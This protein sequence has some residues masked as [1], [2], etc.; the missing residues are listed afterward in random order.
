MA[1]TMGD[2]ARKY[3]AQT[4]EVHPGHAAIKLRVRVHVLMTRVY[5]H[6][7][8]NFGCAQTAIK[9]TVEEYQVLL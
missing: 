6:Q 4:G 5:Q 9:G 3:K 1:A 2:L 8:L 7:S